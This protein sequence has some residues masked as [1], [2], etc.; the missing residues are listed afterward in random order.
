MRGIGNK[1]YR[2]EIEAR[3]ADN[4]SEALTE[5]DRL[6]LSADLILST[7]L[8]G[9]ENLTGDGDDDV[10]EYSPETAEK[11]VRSRDLLVFRA[12]IMWAAAQVGKARPED[13]VRDILEG[14]A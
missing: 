11:L 2:A 12:L 7:I 3:T 4:A 6:E 9:W 5:E 10:I 8:L 13:S 1:D 14:T